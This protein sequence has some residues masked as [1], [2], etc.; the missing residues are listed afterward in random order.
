MPVQG[1]QSSAQNGPLQDALLQI[2]AGVIRDR[3]GQIG[4][5]NGGTGGTTTTPSSQTEV[6]QLRAE[7]R[8]MRSDLSLRIENANSILQSQGKKL[9]ENEAAIKALQGKFEGEGEI[10]R[11]LTDMRAEIDRIPKGNGRGTPPALPPPPANPTAPPGA[12]GA[13][14][15]VRPK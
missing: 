14:G 8:E 2:V 13:A 4:G 12:S 5:G 1:G 15:P 9:I 11:L 7:M 3:L 10:R 6:G